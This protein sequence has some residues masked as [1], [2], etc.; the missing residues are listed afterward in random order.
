MCVLVMGGGEGFLSGASNG[1]QGEN[2]S[3]GFFGEEG[4]INVRFAKGQRSFLV[5]VQVSHLPPSPL[6]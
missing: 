4:G 2:G 3:H 1:V 5:L 6:L